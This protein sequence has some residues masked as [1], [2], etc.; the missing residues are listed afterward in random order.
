MFLLTATNEEEMLQSALAMS[1]DPSPAS[2][3]FSPDNFDAMTEE[4][5]IAFALQMSLA[6]DAEAMDAES[7][8]APTASAVEA[9]TDSTPVPV[10]CLMYT[11]CL[12]NGSI[13][14]WHSL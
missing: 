5:Q 2:A 1:V 13:Q 11:L 12:L 14:A 8:P 9:A 10:S 4:Q 7:T 6:N 3:A